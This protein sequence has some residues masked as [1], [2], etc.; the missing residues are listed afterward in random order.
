MNHKGA[1]RLR[2]ELLRSMIKSII[3]HYNPWERAGIVAIAIL[4]WL[5]NLH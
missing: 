1:E 5:I 3:P 4:I 2:G